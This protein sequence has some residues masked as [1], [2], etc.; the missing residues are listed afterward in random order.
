MTGGKPAGKQKFI[1]G[2][3][4]FSEHIFMDQRIAPIIT[5]RR[6]VDILHISQL[7]QLIYEVSCKTVRMEQAIDHIVI[8]FDKWPESGHRK[9]LVPVNIFEQKRM[10]EVWHV[11][12]NET[13]LSDNFSLPGLCG[14]NG[15][16]M[17]FFDQIL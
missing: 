4:A 5:E 2:I 10:L 8:I 7:S 14:D 16:L 13:V 11:M 12:Y 6:T 3:N 1:S 9:G 15:H 17:A